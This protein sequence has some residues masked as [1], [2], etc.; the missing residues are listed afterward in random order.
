MSCHNTLLR[1]IGHLLEKPADLLRTDGQHFDPLRRASARDG[2][3]F[4]VVHQRPVLACQFRVI[5][6]VVWLLCT[7]LMR[8]AEGL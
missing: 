7:S 3:S 6:S 1:L 4:V 5:I 2:C 8:F